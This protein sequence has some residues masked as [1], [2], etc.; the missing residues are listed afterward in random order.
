MGRARPAP[1]ARPCLPLFATRLGFIT[2]VK[3]EDAVGGRLPAPLGQG[4]PPLAASP[5]DGGPRPARRAMRGP[6]PIA[7]RA[8]SGLLWRAKPRP[9]PINSTHLTMGRSR[10]WV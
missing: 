4:A 1:P 7:A 8:F 5:T 3:T 2:K 6:P 10:F 9:T